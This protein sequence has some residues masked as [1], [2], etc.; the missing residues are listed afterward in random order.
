M[1]KIMRSTVMILSIAFFFN[2]SLMAQEDSEPQAPKFIVATT[3]HWDVVGDTPSQEDWKAT[4]KEFFDKVTSQNE[5]ILGAAVMVHYF[6]ADNSELIFIATYGSWA[7]IEAGQ[8]RSGELINE[9]WPNE[10]E[11]KAFFKKRNSAYT[12]LHSDEIYAPAPG[13]KV[14]AENSGETM[15]MY[16]QKSKFAFPEDGS[17]DEYTQLAKEYNDA[18]T[19]KNDLIKAYYPNYHSWGADRRD[20]L[21][22]SVFSSLA[23][24]EKS[25]E[26]TEEL[27]NAAWPDEAKRKEFFK[28]SGKYFTGEHSDYIYHSVPE[29][30]K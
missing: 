27:V 22:V 25:F 16:F 18:V 30:S 17:Q 9:A 2:V 14:P 20:F 5:Y 1:K 4:E 6:T 7:D 3:F 8:K 26:K 29:L 15:V 19:Q 13:V 28:K 11:R 21:E 10:E 23:D 12:D 24:I